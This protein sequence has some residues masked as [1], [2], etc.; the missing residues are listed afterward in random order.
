M[1]ENVTC[2]ISVCDF[3]R[4]RVF[5]LSQISTIVSYALEL[6]RLRRASIFATTKTVLH[7]SVTS[8]D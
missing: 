4:R 8:T 3:T 2:Q 6:E 7:T 5:Y 1:V